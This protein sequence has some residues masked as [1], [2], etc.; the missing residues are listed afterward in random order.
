M[1]VL[2][3]KPG[4]SILIGENVLLTVL[5]VTGNRVRLGIQAPPEVRIFRSELALTVDPNENPLK[6]VTEAG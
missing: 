4:E 2:S 3:R 5:E 1:L 6:L